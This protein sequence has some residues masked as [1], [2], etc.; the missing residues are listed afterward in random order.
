MVT[1]KAELHWTYIGGIERGE[2]NVSLL[3]IVQLAGALGI[4]PSNLLAV[5][6]RS[7]VPNWRLLE[8]AVTP[9]SGLNLQPLL[10]LSGLAQVCLLGLLLSQPC[11]EGSH[12]LAEA[13]RL[14]VG[15]QVPNGHER[16]AKSTCAAS[17]SSHRREAHL[18]HWRRAFSNSMNHSAL[19]QSL[20]Q[21]AAIFMIIAVVR[22]LAKTDI[23]AVS[24]RPLGFRNINNR[25][26]CEID[27]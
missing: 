12:V 5:S 22:F 23:P 14:S 6:G 1:E 7:V 4:P 11:G 21:N 2:W 15:V 19:Q 10:G 13:E 27:S 3:N 8:T 24:L 20:C 17:P 9:N 26:A 18:G 25:P 16:R